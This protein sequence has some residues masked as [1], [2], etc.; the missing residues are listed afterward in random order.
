M[1]YI[2]SL[3][4]N[5]IRKS[6]VSGGGGY[7]KIYPK[8]LIA[9]SSEIDRIYIIDR[10]TGEYF[11]SL[12]EC[13]NLTLNGVVYGSA[14]NFVKKFNE[15]MGNVISGSILEYNTPSGGEVSNSTETIPANSVHSITIVCTG[16]SAVITIGSK[17]ITIVVGQS[18]SWE[19]TNL[20]DTDI[21]ID[22]SGAG[23][24]VD[25]AVIG[26]APTT[27]ST[28]T[29]APTTTTSTTLAPTTTTTTTT[30]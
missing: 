2:D 20:L 18:F 24:S 3:D 6:N 17:T 4:A 9:Y 16:G 11:V 26:A 28:T 12:A 1:I 25:Y 22:A 5:T 23:N 7:D 14:V 13:T 27:T 8:T 19:A 15:I 30:P 29:E 10:E 21:E